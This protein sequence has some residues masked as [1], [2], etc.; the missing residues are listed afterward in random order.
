[1]TFLTLKQRVLQKLNE[2]I[3]APQFWS[4]ATIGDII[5][6]AYTDLMAGI[7]ILEKSATLSL[8]A[9]QMIYSLASDSLA[10]FRMYYDTSEHL[11]A[12]LSFDSLI[13]ID[14]WFSQTTANYPTQRIHNVGT[15]K[16]LLY[17][18]VETSESDCNTYWY[19]YIPSDMSE[20][21]D[22]PDIPKTFH[23]ALMDYAFSVCLLRVSSRE[24]KQ[25]SAVY[26]QNYET[27]KN[28]LETLSHN[29]VNKTEYMRDWI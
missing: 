11:I 12:S 3:S 16:V 20:D 19:K 4:L 21:S 7:K 2:S 9:N 25:K 6:E 5:N 28:K 8:V 23:D 29:Q 26:L 27:K 22:T 15:Q 24:A 17:P 18:K 1:M 10:V 13:K 14:G